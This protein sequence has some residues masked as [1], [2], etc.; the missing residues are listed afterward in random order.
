M[1]NDHSL[2]MLRNQ[3][4]WSGLYCRWLVESVLVEG[5]TTLWCAN[6]IGARPELIL[7]DFNKA[8]WG[9]VVES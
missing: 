2:S 4:G 1:R 9:E 7:R 3:S 5:R 6:Q 8:V